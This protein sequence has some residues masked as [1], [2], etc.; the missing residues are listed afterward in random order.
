MKRLMHKPNTKPTSDSRRNMIVFLILLAGLLMAQFPWYLFGRYTSH[1]AS[2]YTICFTA[3]S[4]TAGTALWG[5]FFPRQKWPPYLTLLLGVLVALAPDT[6]NYEM[7]FMTWSNVISGAT[8]FVLSV[9]W[10]KRQAP[11]QRG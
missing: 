8:I 1:L 10:I 3:G 11:R 7:P 4:L 9:M 2:F 5:L 6:F